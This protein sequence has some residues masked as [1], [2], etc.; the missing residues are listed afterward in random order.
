M[1]SYMMSLTREEQRKQS[2]REGARL[3]KWCRALLRKMRYTPHA[4][5]AVA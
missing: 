3:K 1:A 2:L 5:Q 4:S